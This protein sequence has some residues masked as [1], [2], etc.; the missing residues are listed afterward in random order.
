[1]QTNMRL[2]KDIVQTQGE[3]RLGHSSD[4]IR[5]GLSPKPTTEVMVQYDRSMVPFAFFTFPL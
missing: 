3:I 5:L 1:M 2:K 4:E